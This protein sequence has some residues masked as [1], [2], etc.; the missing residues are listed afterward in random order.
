LNKP[1]AVL[2][3]NVS[4]LG[5]GLPTESVSN[6]LYLERFGPIY[7]DGK[8]VDPDMIS[9]WTGVESRYMCSDDETLADLLTAASLGAIKDAGWP[10][11][12]V[13]DK[14]F[15]GT[16][17]SHKFRET[18]HTHPTV[19]RRL[20]EAGFP[21]SDSVTVDTA[22]AS[23]GYAWNSAY[24]HFGTGEIDRAIVVGGDTVSRIVDKTDS[25]TL[26]MA[27]GAGAIAMER[28]EVDDAATTPGVLTYFE[29]GD[30]SLENQLVAE[31]RSYLE[32][33]EGS[34]L[35]RASI[36]AMLGVAKRF[37]GESSGVSVDEVA[38]EVSMEP[39]SPVSADQIAIVVPHQPGIKIIDSVR[40][41]LERDYGLDRNKVVVTV[42]K[43]G[44]TSSGCI[45]MALHDAYV[46][47]RINEGDLV[48]MATV[49]TG[50]N[51]A[52]N[53]VRMGKKAPAVS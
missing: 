12:T 35:A 45:P 22:C 5:V 7:H 19:Q 27:D 23:F 46:N 44:N 43:Y 25:R 17:T 20:T 38:T 3:V 8:L 48:M 49:G 30:G 13:I 18:P 2:G 29:G 21:T 9:G 33:R 15:V 47:G 26:M 11:G 10:E 24:R 6:K 51:F 37:F 39:W 36:R 31:T 52:G 34:E 4:G 42:D 50:I 16:A 1:E 53:I 14:L 40:R 28:V 41:R 32:M